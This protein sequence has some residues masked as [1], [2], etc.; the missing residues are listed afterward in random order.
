VR[1]EILKKWTANQ[2]DII[3]ATVPSIKKIIGEEGGT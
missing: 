2:I 3:I 1:T